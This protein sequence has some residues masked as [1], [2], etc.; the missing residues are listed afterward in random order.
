VADLQNSAMTAADGLT[1]QERL[2]DAAESVIADVG[3][4]A[5]S[6]RSINAAAG[7]NVAAAHYHFGSKE[8]LVKAALDRRMG[9]L[10]ERRH[11][12]FSDLGADDPPLGDIVRAHITP[13]IEFVVGEGQTRYLKFL[14]MLDRAGGEWSAAI[15]EAFLPQA[16]RI[17]A[18]Y[19]AALPHLPAATVHARRIIA[20]H[21]M[22]EVLADTSMFF[23]EPPPQGVVV[24]AL[25]DIMLGILTV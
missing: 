13:F 6:L 17:D 14:V 20:A 25:A 15:Q 5:A 1:T 2:L 8:A 16:E 21:V 4:E 3:V 24:D 22:W 23:G 19:A 18:V 12:L 11:E 7:A 9:Q 10:G